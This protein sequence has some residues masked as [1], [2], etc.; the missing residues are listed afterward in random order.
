MSTSMGIYDP[1]NVQV[2]ESL[3]KD[4]TASHA[5]RAEPES[6]DYIKLTDVRRM[7]RN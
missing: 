3:L 2:G 1:V 4:F 6:F 5:S 7:M